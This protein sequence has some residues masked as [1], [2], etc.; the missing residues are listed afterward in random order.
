LISL[1]T[2]DYSAPACVKF[3]RTGMGKI[4][5][6]INPEYSPPRYT[7]VEQRPNETARPKLARDLGLFHLFQE[8]IENQH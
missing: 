2:S 8:F 1:T 3:L 4:S 7:L 6:K 5:A